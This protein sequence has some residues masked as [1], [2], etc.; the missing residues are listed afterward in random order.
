[1]TVGYYVSDVLEEPTATTMQWNAEN[2]LPARA[3]VL[4]DM[5]R[6]IF[7]QGRAPVHHA[8]K[9]QNWC[10]SNFPGIWVNEKWPGIITDLAPIENVSVIVKEELSKM[11][12]ASSEKTPFNNT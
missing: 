5:S 3:E 11:H 10:P 12:K 8:R 2:G 4:S 6:V 7:Q 9:T 1:M